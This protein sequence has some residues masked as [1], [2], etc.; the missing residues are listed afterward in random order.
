MLFPSENVTVILT[1]IISTFHSRWKQ[2][3]DSERSDEYAN[4]YLVEKKKL[5]SFSDPAITIG[6]KDYS[7]EKTRSGR[8]ICPLCVKEGLTSE[9]DF[10]V[11]NRGKGFVVICGGLMVGWRL[12]TRPILNGEVLRVLDRE[13]TMNGKIRQ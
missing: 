2:E 10:D 6:G 7:Y 1:G 3:A 13:S 8:V 9:N 5:N 11:R 12:K 4:K